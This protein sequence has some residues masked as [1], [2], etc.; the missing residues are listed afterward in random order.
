MVK[1]CHKKKWVKI[2]FWFYKIGEKGEFE[3]NKA[4]LKI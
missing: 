4:Y 3:D 1:V 2:C